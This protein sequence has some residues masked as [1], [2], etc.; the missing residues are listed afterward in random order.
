MF[1]WKRTKQAIKQEPLSAT[2]D[3]DFASS[4]IPITKM[5]TNAPPRFDLLNNLPREI[6]DMIFGYMVQNTLNRHVPQPNGFRIHTMRSHL[7]TS[8]WFTPNK[9]HCVEYL[10]VFLRSAEMIAE[11]RDPWVK[12]CQQDIDFAPHPIQLEDTL[13]LINRRFAIAARDTGHQSTPR[14]TFPIHQRDLL[15]LLLLWRLLQDRLWKMGFPEISI[16]R[17]FRQ[18][19]EKIET[20]P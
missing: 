6:R 20:V 4:V 17:L 11:I 9:Q 15:Q 13:Q 16:Q 10:K 7:I 3:H 2:D 19:C 12:T 14:G 1:P 5:S 18:A 8:P